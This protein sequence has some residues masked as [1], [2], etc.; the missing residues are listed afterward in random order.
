MSSLPEGVN[1]RDVWVVLPAYNEGRVIGSVIAPILR[2]GYHVVVVDDASTDRTYQEACAA[3]AHVCRH[4]INLGQGAALQTGIAYALAKGAAYVVTFDADGQ[5]LA[6]D[7][8]A[9]LQCL[10]GQGCDV[11]LGTRFA[12][13]SRAEDMPALRKWVLK[14]ATLYLRL[15]VGVRVT[16]AHNG[17]RAFTAA[18]AA[19]LEIRQ[20]RMAHASEILR[21]IRTR[22]LR[23]AEVPVTI[24]Y[25]DY[26]LAKGQKVHNAINILWDSFTGLFLR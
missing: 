21:Q 2:E 4:L 7:I 19:Q 14:L 5:H 22:G 9:L 25:T 15:S 16:D 3:R 24:R 11:A 26:S 20:N 23:Y 13:G 17:L 18:A 8:P 1:P 10:V 6:S 12:P